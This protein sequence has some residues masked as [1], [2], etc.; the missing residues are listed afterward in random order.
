[1][2]KYDKKTGLIRETIGMITL[3]LRVFDLATLEGLS[4]L[5]GN[6]PGYI[7]EAVE[8]TIWDC[9]EPEDLE[10]FRENWLFDGVTKIQ[11]RESGCD[12]CEAYGLLRDLVTQVE[13]I[14]PAIR[15]RPEDGIEIGTTLADADRFLKVREYAFNENLDGEQDAVALAVVVGPDIFETVQELS[16]VAY[17]GSE[18]GR[19]LIFGPLVLRNHF[20]D[21]EG[22]DTLT[23]NEQYLQALATKAVNENRPS[24]HLWKNRGE[25]K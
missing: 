25:V 16:D 10:T 9:A 12:M 13:A 15:L 14:I 24:L 20:E 19:C 11:D 6:E 22:N 4:I 17:A 2:D 18:D 5:L 8:Q 1:M 23:P 21:T 3:D 7:K